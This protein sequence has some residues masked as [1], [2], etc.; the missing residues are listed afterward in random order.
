MIIV[1]DNIQYLPKDRPGQL[2]P[3]NKIR[4]EAYKAYFKKIKNIFSSV[5]DNGH[6]AEISVIGK[7]EAHSDTTNITIDLVSCDNPD[8]EETL[9]QTAANL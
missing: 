2:L 5:P 6:H 8:L 1:K 7:V 3:T 9:R 4:N